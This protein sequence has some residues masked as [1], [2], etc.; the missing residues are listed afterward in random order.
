MANWL[1]QAFGLVEPE[2]PAPTP[3]R[4]PPEVKGFICVVRQPSGAPGDLGET[5]D[6]WY[7]VEHGMVTLCDQ[8]GKPITKSADNHSDLSAVLT[9]GDDPRRI[10]SRLRR[11]AWQGE[12]SPFDR[13][14]YQS[15]PYGG[16]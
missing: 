14:L 9:T 13:P 7:F 15:T 2:A 8:Q 1:E 4:G 16:Y 3:R 12:R 11:A 10:A 5:V 6:S